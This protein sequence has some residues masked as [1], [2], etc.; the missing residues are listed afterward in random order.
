MSLRVSSPKS[1]P[2]A[3]V[4]LRHIMGDVYVTMQRRK[5]YIEAKWQGH[6]T[7]DDV[8][9]AAQAYLELILLAP[10]PYLLNDKSD[11]TG[12][13]QEAN[14]WLQYEWLPKVKQAGLRCLAHVYSQNMFSKLA[15]RELEERLYPDLHMKNFYE[16]SKAEAWL[17]QQ[18]DESPTD[19]RAA[20]A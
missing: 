7:A 4:E 6:I 10:C 5:K 2:L 18:G 19:R 17:L 8:I 1:K 11:V 12:D 16:R 3:A 9:C 13:W 14:D 20:T 15:A